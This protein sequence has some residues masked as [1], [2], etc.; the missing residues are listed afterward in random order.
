MKKAMGKKRLGVWFTVWL[1]LLAALPPGLVHGGHFPSPNTNVDG[2]VDFLIKLNFNGLPPSPGDEVAFFDSQG[3]ILGLHVIVLSDIDYQY[4]PMHVYA[5]ET[6]AASNQLKVKAWQATT[7]LEFSERTIFLSG[8]DPLGSYRPS[9][10]P[11]IFQDKD[12]FTLNIEATFT[13][14][15]VNHDTFVDIKDAIIILRVLSGGAAT[16]P[17]YLGNPLELADAIFILQKIARTRP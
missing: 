15:D 17:I 9:P 3:L 7:Q 12:G 8:G 14:G 10:V 1:L 11:P 13:K 6:T 5:S 4:F 16:G 2:S